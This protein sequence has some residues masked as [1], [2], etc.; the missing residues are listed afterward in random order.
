VSIRVIVSV[1]V[2]LCVAVTALSLYLG[3]VERPSAFAAGARGANAPA[4]AH[5]TY[6]QCN[7][8][9]HM[10]G[11]S[12]YSNVV[13][14]IVSSTRSVGPAGDRLFAVLTVCPTTARAT[15]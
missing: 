7:G 14:N 8:I 5:H 12:A 15:K 11:P 9:V 6:T 4:A 2:V 10:R 1:G 3:G 13:S